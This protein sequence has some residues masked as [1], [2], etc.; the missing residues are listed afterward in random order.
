MDTNKIN[1]T[2]LVMIGLSSGLSVVTKPIALFVIFPVIFSILLTTKSS[3]TVA[4][5]ILL[6]LI[7]NFSFYQFWENYKKNNNP[8]LKFELLDSI[9]HG[10][11]MTALRAGMVDNGE[12]TPLYNYIVENG[13]LDEAKNFKIKMS[14]TMNTQENYLD[15]KNSIPWEIQ[16]DKSFAIQIIKTA[17]L[18]IFL[19][20]I[21]N[22]HSFFTKRSFGPGNES[23]PGMPNI[24]RRLYYSGYSLLYRPFLLF[25]LIF[26]FYILWVRKTLEIL[27]PSVSLILFASLTVAVLTAHGGEF[28]RYRVWVEYLMW[29]CSL[30][31]LGFLIQLLHTKFKRV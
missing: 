20:S 26:S 27:Y 13:M 5:S 1:Y 17:P 25:M 30:I 12:G 9:E 21:S 14:Y 23:F 24:M 19:S 7:I 8:E 11:N 22:W 18:K 29:F 31:P 6:I 4:K 10:I 28:P 16:N 3:W 2:Y 15:F